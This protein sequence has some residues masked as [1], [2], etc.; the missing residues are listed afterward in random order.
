MCTLLI[1][2]LLFS[3][4]ATNTD[5]FLRVSHQIKFLSDRMRH[6][7]LQIQGKP[8]ELKA[9]PTKV[10]NIAVFDEDDDESFNC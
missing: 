2:S 9:T 4:S 8:K 1:L 6:L 10:K 5:Y 3:I 7:E